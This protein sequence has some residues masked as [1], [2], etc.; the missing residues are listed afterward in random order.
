MGTVNVELGFEE[1]DTV[2]FA[3]E[4]VC[5]KTTVSVSEETLERWKKIDLEYK[6]MQNEMKKLLN[7]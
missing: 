2:F 7:E 3:G 6:M 4:H 1:I 5:C